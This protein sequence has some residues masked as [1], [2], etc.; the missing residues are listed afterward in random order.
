MIQRWITIGSLLILLHCGIARAQTPDNMVYNPSFEEYIRCPQKIEALGIMTEVEA[1]WQP[2]KGSSDYF[3]ACG[4]RDCAVPRNK[5]GYQTAHNGQAYCG[6]YCSQASYREYLQTELKQPLKA[7]SRYRVSFWVSLADKA[8]HAV[9]TLGAFFSREMISDTTSWDILMERET[10][11]SKENENII[12]ATYLQPQVVNH[13]DSI[14]TNSKEWHE[15]VGEFVAEG[16][17]RFLTIGNFADFNHSKVTDINNTTSVLQGAYYYIDDVCVTS[18]DNPDSA[19]ETVKVPAPKEG[20]VKT[21]HGI[22]FA[23]GK[24]DILPQSYNALKHLLETLQENPEMRIELRGHT[25]DQGTASFNMKLSE[26]RAAA[27]AIYLIG[28]GIDEKRLTTLGFGKTMPVESNATPEGR[29]RNR[30]VEYRVLAD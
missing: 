18:L 11:D 19:T 30:R 8:P 29:S 9:A 24:S 28:K 26:A 15:I 20:E 1:W 13:K 17:E 25:D 16:G 2:T 21:L 5:M 14:L 22:Y 3:N 23:T 10:P 12:I 6:I 27:V 7:G 4:S